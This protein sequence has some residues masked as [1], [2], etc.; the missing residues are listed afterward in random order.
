MENDNIEYCKCKNPT[1]VYSE[2]N[3]MG[4]W[5]ICCDCNKIVEDSFEYHDGIAP[6][7]Y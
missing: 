5:D 4:Y 6:N 2:C 1:G 3:D 7:D